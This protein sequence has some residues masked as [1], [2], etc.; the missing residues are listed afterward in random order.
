[1]LVGVG[2]ILLSTVLFLL[3]GYVSN[4]PTFGKAG[5]AN[6]A[7]V[8]LSQVV[9]STALIGQNL[10]PNGPENGPV[11]LSQASKVLGGKFP[12]LESAI[13]KYP[14]QT[15]IFQ[16]YWTTGGVGANGSIIIAVEMPGP[17]RAHLLLTEINS[18]NPV[19]GQAT[20]QQPFQVNGIPGGKGF[21]QSVPQPQSTPLTVQVVTFRVTNVVFEVY[22]ASPTGHYSN[23]DAVTLA[24]QQ[25]QAAVAN[26]PTVPETTQTVPA[27]SQTTNPTST[28]SNHDSNMLWLFIGVA[29]LGVALVV[30]MTLYAT[31]RKKKQKTL[32]EERGLVNAMRLSQSEPDNKDSGSHNV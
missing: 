13:A 11:E 14:S 21:D 7:Q 12:T 31:S 29:V 27:T 10:D 23:A 17:V 28:T 9:I 25:Y 4:Y 18:Q 20:T 8:D 19:G 32:W 5:K 30:G 16:R 22:L 6:A 2:V 1:M 3:S 26:L 24:T 15:A